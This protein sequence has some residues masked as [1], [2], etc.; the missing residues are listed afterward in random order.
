MCIR[1][2]DHVSEAFYR[3][4]ASRSRAQGGSG[5][6]L[7]LCAKIAELHQG[8]LSVRSEIGIGTCVTVDLRAG[9]G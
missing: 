7:S 3:V 4:D 2:S 1:D 5:L 6:G 9:R 8:S